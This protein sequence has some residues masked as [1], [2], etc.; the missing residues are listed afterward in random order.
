MLAISGA[1]LSGCRSHPARPTITFT[2][3]PIADSGGSEKHDIIEGRVTGGRADQ[4]IV[5]YAKSGVWWVQ[6]L[7]AEPF[8]RVQKSTKWSNATHLGTEYA[9]LLVDPGFRAPATMPQLPPVEGA[10]AAIASVPGGK[11]QPS[12]T[13]SF[14]GY[15]WRLRDAPSARGG[16]NGYDPA[17]VWVD[18]DGRMHLRIAKS[19]NDWSCAEASLT[20]SLGFGTYS[21]TVE[22]TSSID[23]AAVLG[24]FTFDYSG[25]D[26]NYHEMAIEISRW[27][28]PLI[29]GGQYVVQP[30]YV[31]ANVARFSIPRGTLTHSF[32][33]HPGVVSFRTVK[34]SKAD[35][36]L[37]AVAE[38]TFTSGIPTHGIESARMNLY[39]FRSAKIPFAQASEVIVDRFEFLP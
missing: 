38:H 23:P 6:P 22:D 12:K 17:N 8:T 15:E 9:A 13:I 27:G 26:E 32:R 25:A 2:R 35:A 33:W 30:Y 34:G 14:S 7:A 21:F 24:M 1:F 18:A 37:A 20:R 39:V 5:L 29:K 10:V 19:A 4:Q 3:I 28:D 16:G 36:S 31:A 11:T